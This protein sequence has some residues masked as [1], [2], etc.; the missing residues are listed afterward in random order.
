MAFTF[1]AARGVAVGATQVEAGSLE[2]ARAASDQAARGGA[3]LLLPC[4]VLVSDS[5]GAA[6]NERVVPLT[7]DCCSPAVPCL[8]AGA[9]GVDVGPASR[10]AFAAH[11]AAAR[12]VLWNGPVGKF[13]VPA[14]G[15]GTAAMARALAAAFAS[16]ATAVAAGGDTLAALHAAGA[17]GGVTHASTGGGASLQLLEGQSM[18]GLEALL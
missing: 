11:I 12:T 2:A 8:P 7:P 1:L 10:H 4:D 18:P 5:P 16:G 3:R 14:F 13:E 6:L 17:A 9:F 15:G